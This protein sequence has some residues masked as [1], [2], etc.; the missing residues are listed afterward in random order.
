MFVKDQF[1]IWQGNPDWETWFT[2]KFDKDTEI[3]ISGVATEFCVKFNALGYKKRGFNNIF[4][5]EKSISAIDNDMK[6]KTFIEFKENE[7]KII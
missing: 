2:N 5:E 4:V 7:I 6:E 3:Y 1:D